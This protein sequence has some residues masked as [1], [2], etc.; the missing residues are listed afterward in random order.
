MNLLNYATHDSTLR[1]RMITFV[2]NETA[3]WKKRRDVEAQQR[4]ERAAA[5]KRAKAEAAPSDAA[6]PAA[7]AAAIDAAASSAGDA[8][9]ANASVPASADSL[10]DTDSRMDVDGTG[11]EDDDENEEEP[12]RP[13]KR[14][15]AD[16][17]AMVDTD[18]ADAAL[19]EAADL[20]GVVSPRKSKVRGRARSRR[21]T[22]A[23]E[24]ATKSSKKASSTLGRSSTIGKKRK[25]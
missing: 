11:G 17:S 12:V 15:R 2:E 5:K 19:R 6:A 20:V 18:D 24:R 23:G 1:A 21:Y 4:R 13:A 25:K 7:A 9:I 3:E 22:S 8:P 14:Y 10:A 16:E